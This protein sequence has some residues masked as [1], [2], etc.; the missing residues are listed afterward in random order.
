MTD[1]NSYKTLSTLIKALH[2]KVLA[3]TSNNR[4]FGLQVATQLGILIT[5]ILIISVN[6]LMFMFF[7]PVIFNL[8]EATSL[9]N[10]A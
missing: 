6:N 9:A 1:I 7:A 5:F 10:A 2:S 3:L 4:P 8:L